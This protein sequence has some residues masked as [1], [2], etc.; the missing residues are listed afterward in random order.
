MRGTPAR[1][2]WRDFMEMPRLARIRQRF[3][4]EAIDDV[5]AAVHAAVVKSGIAGRLQPGAQVAITAGS[6]G[7]ARIPTI[8]AAL[9]SSLRGLGDRAVRRASDG[10]SR[11]RNRRRPAVGPRRLRHHRGHRRGA[12]PGHDGGSAA[13]D[14]AAGRPGLYGSQC[15]AGGRHRGGRS[16]QAAHRV[17]RVHR[18]RAVQNARHRAGQA[19][20][21]RGHPRPWPGRA[22]P[23]SGRP[24]PSSP[25]R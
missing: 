15:G 5:P 3:P 25:R 13:R 16:G 17:S 7:I 1:R 8:L 23:G 18:E 10:Q 2:A 4:A 21:R 24:L 11:R 9:V 14:H 22:H 20:R 6:R 19:A 12:D